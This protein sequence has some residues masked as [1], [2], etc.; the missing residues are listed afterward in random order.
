MEHEKRKRVASTSTSHELSQHELYVSFL[1]SDEEYL[2]QTS[3][4]VATDTSRKIGRKDF[5]SPKLAAALDR[6]QCLY[7]SG[8]NGSARFQH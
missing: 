4:V 6:C 1:S 2:P 8:Y 3:N 7:Y 5:V